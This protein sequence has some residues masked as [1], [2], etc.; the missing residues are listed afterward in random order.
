MDEL[1]GFLS[2]NRYVSPYALLVFYYLGAVL[3]P[4]AM[5]VFWIWLRRRY[6]ALKAV[7][8]QVADLRKRV[9]S[10]VQWI[11]ILLACIFCF[12]LAELF[13]RM[14]FEFMMAYFHIAIDL[15]MLVR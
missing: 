8:G 2:F 9:L 12:L 13:W 11:G 4:L 5:I 10:P 3:M 6:P 15:Q 14:M 7:Q 1:L